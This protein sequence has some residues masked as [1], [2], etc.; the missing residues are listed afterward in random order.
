MA[1]KKKKASVPAAGEVLWDGSAEAVEKVK[2]LFPGRQ[3]EADN[4]G[5]IFISSRE[6]SSLMTARKGQVITTRGVR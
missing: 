1:K 6:D 2:A 5:S 3:V 4:Y